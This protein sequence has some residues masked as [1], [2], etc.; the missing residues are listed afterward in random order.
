MDEALCTVD[1]ADGHCCPPRPHF[2]A[3]KMSA[4]MGAACVSAVVVNPFDVVKVRSPP[5]A[6]RNVPWLSWRL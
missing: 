5:W 1:C 6:F 4:G 3:A 2:S